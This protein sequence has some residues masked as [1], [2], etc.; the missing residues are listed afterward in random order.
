[1]GYL[2][3]F[4]E[5]RELQRWKTRRLVQYGTKRE[6]HGM[7][8]LLGCTRL[9]GE[10]IWVECVPSV[11]STKGKQ[12]VLQIQNKSEIIILKGYVLGVCIKVFYFYKTQEVLVIINLKP[13]FSA[14]I[15]ASNIKNSGIRVRGACITTDPS[16][17]WIVGYQPYCRSRQSRQILLRRRFRNHPWAGKHNNLGILHCTA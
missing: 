10:V 3:V 9:G 12:K 7:T 13:G 16:G 8:K 2:K 11:P 5:S 14:A 1:M 6:D 17:H 15:N 4:T